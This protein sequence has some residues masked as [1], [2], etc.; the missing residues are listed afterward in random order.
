MPSF[1]PGTDDVREYI[2]KAKFLHG[3]FPA[4]DRPNL[5]PRLAMQCKGTAWS[6]VRQLDPEKLT[7]ADSGVE[8]LLS[9]L[10]NWE[11]TSELRTFE[12][13]EKALYK[14]TQKADEA[15]HSYTLRLQA[16]FHD[17]GTKV[18]VSEMQAFILP[19]Q[20]CL[21]NE[22]KKRVLSMS[23]GE[24]SL[25]KMESAMR[26]LSTRVL[27]G[28][29]EVKKKVYPANYVDA[30][31]DHAHNDDETVPHSTYHAAVEEDDVLTAET[32]ESL[33][34]AG[35]EDAMYVQQFEQDLEEMMQG[36][37]D[38][39]SALVSYQEA[40]ARINDR[41]RSRGFWPSKSR[42]KGFSKGFRKGG[43]KHG[44]KEELLARISRTHCKICGALG[45]WK[46]ECPQRKDQPREAANVVHAEEEDL[47]QDLP[48]VLIEE[49]FE[50]GHVSY[51][52]CLVAVPLSHHKHPTCIRQEVCHQVH[53]FW[54]GKLKRYGDKRVR[55][56]WSYGVNQQ[57]NK[58]ISLNMPAKEVH[59]DRNGTM[60]MPSPGSTNSKPAECLN[61]QTTVKPASMT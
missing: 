12:L 43:S 17:L 21:S 9:A 25:T 58:D 28:S 44:G 19:R 1:D 27:F 35:D 18:T 11:E 55:D 46:A 47:S 4:K 3:V 30:S 33:A 31:D 61:S 5:A 49:N 13:F 29:G 20:S 34:Q 54:S 42:G 48:Q 32:V 56:K 24:L 51:E 39:Q 6:Q 38:L 36:I 53:R 52:D 45:H 7:N 57:K 8:Y 41:K 37:P 22:D 16:A 40:R 2:Q 14:V 26:T 10:A 59:P 50:A 60:Q 15:T 23:G